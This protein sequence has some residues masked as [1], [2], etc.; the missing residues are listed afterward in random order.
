MN[1]F[2]RFLLGLSWSVYFLWICSAHAACGDAASFENRLR[3]ALN[4]I[5]NQQ[6]PLAQDCLESA[7]SENRN[8]AR[9]AYLFGM[10]DRNKNQGKRT[11]LTIEH[12][13]R[14]AL[15]AL[16]HEKEFYQLEYGLL[17]LEQPANIDKARQELE[18]IDRGMANLLLA[19]YLLRV[20]TGFTDWEQVINS[21]AIFAE[22]LKA[23]GRTTDSGNVQAIRAAIRAVQID[24]QP[25]PP[26]E[27]AWRDAIGGTKENPSTLSAL[28]ASSP[29]HP[30]ANY[31]AGF[32]YSSYRKQSLPM[33]LDEAQ[34][35]RALKAFT[36]GIPEV[37]LPELVLVNAEAMKLLR[38]RL[39]QMESYLQERVSLLALVDKE[40]P[41][42]GVTGWHHGA[43]IR[44]THPHVWLDIW[45]ND[46]VALKLLKV[47]V[48]A[49][50][51]NSKKTYFTNQTV[52]GKT[53]S[54]VYRLG[55][56]MPDLK[57]PGTYR[58]SLE[59]EDKHDRPSGT[60]VLTVKYVPAITSKSI[61]IVG[62]EKYSDDK[63]FPMLGG[64]I[65]ND[66]EP[67]AVAFQGQKLEVL[68]NEKAT[69]A[70]IVEIFQKMR[71]PDDDVL[72]YFSGHGAK[73]TEI[74]SN[75]ICLFD[76][77][78]ME[79]K[80]LTSY[81]ETSRARRIA[82]IIDACFSGNPGLLNYSS[83]DAERGGRIYVASAAANETAKMQNGA[84][85]FTSHLLALLSDDKEAAEADIDND[86]IVTIGEAI[87]H[88]QK[89]MKG[90]VPQVPRLTGSGSEYFVWRE[91][92]HLVM[93]RR[94][95]S[96]LSSSSDSYADIIRIL[97]APGIYPKEII[98]EILVDIG[99]LSTDLL[100]DKPPATLLRQFAEKK[101]DPTPLPP[102]QLKP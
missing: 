38:Q 92:S 17:H 27:T 20:R 24:S 97:D 72:F 94:N 71:D 56:P 49:S 9:V 36:R 67:L 46:D 64:L 98:T 74:S 13:R 99:R 5:D 86:G 16:D 19:H 42:L 62:V 76:G 87:A 45:A 15:H 73:R 21:L 90:R 39:A 6:W 35:A 101:V 61:N 4:A 44:T 66:I 93:A 8:S 83:G 51:P 81:L 28:L 84:S 32:L 65:K 34:R 52:E 82:I 33:D 102:L 69:A 78:C 47:Q 26:S 88:V 43:E 54:R 85:I 70:G 80:P 2:R 14:A 18:K 31:V 89:R 53:L 48:E 55:L 96:R 59:V 58:I 30:M 22:S 77:T 1:H 40:P 37:K 12:F 79:L 50:H 57:L 68:R 91:F 10:L 95:L 29:D 60:F 11:D 23:K 75:T 63:R 7:E 41:S 25:N 3:L 100:I